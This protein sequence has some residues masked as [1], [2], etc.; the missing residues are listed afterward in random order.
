MDSLIDKDYIHKKI[1]VNKNGA[2]A[3]NE[4]LPVK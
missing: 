3:L 2:V 4:L 1:L